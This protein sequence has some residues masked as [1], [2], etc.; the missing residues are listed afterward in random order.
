MRLPDFT[1]YDDVAQPVFALTEDDAGKVVFAFMNANARDRL[2]LRQDQVVGRSADVFFEGRAGVLLLA[3]QTAAWQSGKSV[4]YEMGL[5]VGGGTMWARTR[6]EPVRD[7]NG[8]LVY[9]VGITQDISQER[10]LEEVQA[11]TSAMASEME[12]FVSIA[13][14]DLRSP[15][16]NVKSLVDMVCEDFI[17]MGDGKL[18]LIRMIEQVST[19]ALVLV[20]DVMSQ[21]AAGNAGSEVRTFDLQSLC[22]DILVTLDPAQLHSVK[23]PQIWIKAD[24]IVM[25][26]V[27]RNLIDNALKHASAERIYMEISA[28]NAADDKVVV[29]VCDDGQGFAD[30]ALAFLDGGA[31][32]IDSGFGLLGVRRLVR[33][34]GGEISAVPPT[35]GRGAEVRFELPG[36]VTQVAQDTVCRAEDAL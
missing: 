22:D 2:G 5:P 1:I 18:E 24:Y 36:E 21:A 32:G 34:R 28:E 4:T 30:P 15:I 27:L 25:Q 29:T 17:D 10:A 16:A 35:S 33:G 8:A 9:M 19:R 23:T 11:V 13:A 14:H 31:L 7:E 12:E 26:I 3:R 20:S 6:L